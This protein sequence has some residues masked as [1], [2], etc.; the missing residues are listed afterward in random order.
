MTCLGFALLTCARAVSVPGGRCARGVCESGAAFWWAFAGLSL[1]YLLNVHLAYVLFS[2]HHAWTVRPAFDAIFG[3]AT[4][5]WQRKA[6][7]G[8]TAAACL[9]VA[10]FGWRRLERDH[11]TPRLTASPGRARRSTPDSGRTVRLTLLSP[12]RTVHP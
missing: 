11:N 8:I 10:A 4:D 7:S 3:T 1:C 9:A 2:D 5:A 6:L 12:L